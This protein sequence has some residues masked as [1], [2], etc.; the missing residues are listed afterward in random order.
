MKRLL[1]FVPLLLAVA[2]CAED[3][4]AKIAP[5]IDPAKLATLG[6]RGADSRVQKCVYW[7][8][9]ARKD[10][11]S[12]K[13]VAQAAVS[14]AGYNKKA[15]ALT[16]AALLRNLD[17]AE[18]LGCLDADGMA[19]MRSGSAPTVRKGPY[20]GGIASVDHIIPRAVAPE[21]DNV[22]ANLELLP[23]KV[24]ESKNDKI[25]DRQRHMAKKFHAAGLLSD[26]GLK[27]VESRSR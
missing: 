16:K 6:K 27:A 22:I 9:E 19:K 18:K 24:N 11:E 10:G 2:V 26:A 5:L 23:L 7:L 14:K 8:A 17:I 4:A 20:A 21:L 13:K 15:A 1:L 25:G 3:F 12:P